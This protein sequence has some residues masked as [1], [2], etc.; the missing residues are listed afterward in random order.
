MLYTFSAWYLNSWHC[1]VFEVVAIFVFTFKPCFPQIDFFNWLISYGMDYIF[2]KKELFDV[3]VNSLIFYHH[4]RDF[5]TLDVM[6]KW[7]HG[8]WL[9]R[10]NRRYYNDRVT[11]PNYKNVKFP[12]ESKFFSLKLLRT[13]LRVRHGKTV[14]VYL[15]ICICTHTIA[16]DVNEFWIRK[17]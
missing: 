5:N 6:Q 15:C 12:F 10:S 2:W 16:G 13:R 8:M 9:L 3:I 17:W 1:I 11:T 4:T 7:L 14:N